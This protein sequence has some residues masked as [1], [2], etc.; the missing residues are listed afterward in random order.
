MKKIIKSRPRH[1]DYECV[2]RVCFDDDD[3]IEWLVDDGR[4]SEENAENHRPSVEELRN[5]VYYLIENGDGDY[6]VPYIV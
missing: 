4:L 2:V 3:V 5:Y 6:G 1:H